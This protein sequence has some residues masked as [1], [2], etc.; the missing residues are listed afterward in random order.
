MLARVYVLAGL[1]GMVAASFVAL[2]RVGGAVA[3]AVLSALLLAG[4]L[5]KVAGETGRSDGSA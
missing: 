2:G 3:L 4:G 5:V 1:V